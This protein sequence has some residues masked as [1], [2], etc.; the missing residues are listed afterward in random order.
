MIRPT[1]VYR[2]SRPINPKTGKPG[3]RYN[4]ESWDGPEPFGPLEHYL[5]RDGAPIIYVNRWTGPRDEHKNRAAIGLF[6]ADTEDFKAKYGQGAI[7]GIYEPMPE[8]PGMGYG[9]SPDRKDAFLFLRDDKA[10]TFT[11]AVFPGHGQSR[12]TLFFEWVD[13]AVR[14]EPEGAR[15]QV[16]YNNGHLDTDF[17]TRKDD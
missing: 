11:V 17:V 1:W 10:G 16:L 15:R 9:D 14:L 8:H 5:K 13:G 4:R 12:Q 2:Y 6:P 7:S 3:A